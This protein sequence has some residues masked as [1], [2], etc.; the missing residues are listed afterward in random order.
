MNAVHSTCGCLGEQKSNRGKKPYKQSPHTR[1]TQR[2]GRTLDA[3]NSDRTLGQISSNQQQ[4]PP[5]HDHDTRASTFAPAKSQIPY[6]TT[7]KL[8]PL[9]SRFSRF[10]GVGYWGFLRWSCPTLT[11][12]EEEKGGD[13]N[14]DVRTGYVW[15]GDGEIE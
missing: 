11:I 9:L 12:V 10:F 4:Q 13:G 5:A 2:Q 8:I 14:K 3:H 7:G 15:A 6:V 1:T